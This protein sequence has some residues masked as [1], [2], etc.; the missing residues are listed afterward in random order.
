MSLSERVKKPV[1]PNPTGI[2]CSMG[3]VYRKLSEEPQELAALELLLYGTQGWGRPAHA[4][5]DMLGLEGHKVSIQQVNRHRG[6][7]CRCFKPVN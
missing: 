1:S 2:P 3:E 5:V 7:K 6:K 4:V